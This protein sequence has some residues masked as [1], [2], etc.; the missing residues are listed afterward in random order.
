[1]HRDLVL[2]SANRIKKKRLNHQK[3]LQ[4]LIETS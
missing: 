4:N 1:M 3:Q 2:F